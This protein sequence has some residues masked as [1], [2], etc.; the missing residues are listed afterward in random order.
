MKMSIKDKLKHKPKKAKEQ[1]APVPHRLKPYPV[2]NCNECK[3]C[4]LCVMACPQNVLKMSEKTNSKGYHYVEYDGTKC[5]GCGN[6]YYS[7]PEPF[8]IEVHIPINEKDQ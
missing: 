3:G 5:T 7:C 4:K 1:F 6:C 2:I 8:A